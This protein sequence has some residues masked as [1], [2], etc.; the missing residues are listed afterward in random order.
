MKRGPLFDMLVL[1]LAAT[2][3]DVAA[4]DSPYRPGPGGYPRFQAKEA[5]P[6]LTYGN[7]SDFPLPRT[8][9]YAV[10]A[11]E[12]LADAE[13]WVRHGYGGFFLSGV[14]P[15]WSSDVWAADGAPW[16]IGLS[17]ATLQKVRQATAK[18]RELGA[19]VFLC[20]AFSHLLEWFNDVAWQHIE[21]RFRQ[22][23]LFARDSGCTGVALDIEYIYPQY[24]FSW[25][26][27]TYEGYS[28]RDLVETMRQR[29]QGVAAAMYDAFPDMVLLTLPE[30]MLALGS[31]VQ[32]TWIEE[33]ARRNAPGGVH[34]CTEYTYRRP[35]IRYM[36]GHAW[37][38]NAL[39]E[40]MLSEKG[41]S[42]WREKC[43]IAAGL[44]PFG[45]DPDDFH[46]AEPS[47]EEFRQ[48]FAASLMLGRQYNWVYSHTCRPFFLGRE[49]D[50]YAGKEP[51]ENY[52][53]VIAE[54]AVVT[55]L[56]YVRTAESL[57]KM[58]LRG[59]A[60]D[61]GLTLVPTFAGPREEVEVG[62]MPVTVYESSPV[63]GLK[64]ELWDLGLRVYRGEDID[65]RS[66]FGTQTA[67]ML[68]GP[69]DNAEGK[70]YAEA[71]PPEEGI[72]L[73]A[74]YE[75][76]RENLRWARYAA[77]VRQASVDLTKVMQ[78]TEY[79]CA[80][81]LGYVYS[82]VEQDIQFRVGA[83]DTWKLWA[84]GR[85]V[86]ECREDGRII[87]D[88]EVIPATLKAGVTP[89]L[90]KVCNNKKD[91]GFIFRITDRQGQPLDNL[92]FQTTP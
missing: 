1:L 41:R 31:L 16:T 75:T 78:P 2:S 60:Q 77:P 62:L 42:Y 6:G 23:A 65:F 40:Q 76:A 74:E 32:T 17:D 73:S 69:F 55:D 37:L 58:E 35:N 15:E 27:Y 45:L 68:I 67:W 63:A 20:S 33:A 25:E 4:L 18:C 80:Y 46:G 87:L 83:N 34:V 50:K 9:L 56:E 8:L 26:G 13:V 61:L 29:M 88:R 82:P 64:Q 49:T 71:Y 24:H 44:W 10:T 85:L 48:A 72:D 7:L 86:Q 22:I 19:E 90:L 52:L 5:E 79:V 84:D 81:A 39:L 89:I 91:W 43:S 53:R 21:H 57:R 30:G 59:Y 51:L 12:L 3:F 28:R 38:N 66:T 36:F 14:A 47:V 70:G 54:R 92:T 11:D